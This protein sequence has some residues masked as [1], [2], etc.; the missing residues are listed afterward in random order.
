VKAV[1]P[2]GLGKIEVT[3]IEEVEPGAHELVIEVG[4]YSVNRGET[5]SCNCR[6]TAGARARTS[7]DGW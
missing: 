6:A 7:P 3:D 2:A 1:L 4:A 5:S